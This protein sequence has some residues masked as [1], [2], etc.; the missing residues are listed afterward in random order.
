[1]QPT[2][3]TIAGSDSSGGAGAQADLKTIA[4]CGAHGACAL[5]AVTAQNTR[6]VDA[7]EALPPALVRAQ[8]DAVFGDLD[9]VA[10]KT[11]M[12]ASEAIVL[13]VADAVRSHEPSALVCDPVIV[14]T[15]G[16]RLLTPPGVE[17]MVQQLFPLAAVVTPNVDEAEALSGL[18]PRNAAES[19]QAGRRILDRGARAVLIKGGHLIDDFAADVLVTPTGTRTFV[20]PRIDT[21]PVHGTG[22]VL[23]A[24]IATHLGLGLNLDG[25]IERSKELVTQAI[26]AAREVG[27]GAAVAEPL[28]VLGALLGDRT[29]S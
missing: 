3:L 5:T 18:R 6:G 21:P 24:A 17:A 26:R 14:S 20:A 8:M 4:A 22:C 10:V 1:L 25:A 28:Y 19:E 11:G 12:L 2:I 13:A 9:V 27:G 23:S 7:Q 15:S 29:P 16:H